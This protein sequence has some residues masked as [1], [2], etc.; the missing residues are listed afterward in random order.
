MKSGLLWITF[1]TFRG[2]GGINPLHSPFFTC[3]CRCNQI[4]F[5]DQIILSNIIDLTC[6]VS[7]ELKNRMSQNYLQIVHSTLLHTHLRTIPPNL[8]AFYCR[9]CN[10]KRREKEREREKERNKKLVEVTKHMYVQEVLTHFI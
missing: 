9:F 2:G 7:N 8:S 5:T 3:Q 10:S 1:N 6:I 4:P